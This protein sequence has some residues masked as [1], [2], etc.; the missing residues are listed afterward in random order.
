MSWRDWL[1]DNGAER[2]CLVTGPHT[3]ASQFYAMRGWVR[4]GDPEAHGDVRY[5]LSRP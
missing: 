1:W 3:R 4:T 5:E 2:V